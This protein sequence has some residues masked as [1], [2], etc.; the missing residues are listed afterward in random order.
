MLCSG[1]NGEDAI[2]LLGNMMELVWVPL[3]IK[4]SKAFLHALEV[5]QSIPIP[6]RKVYGSYERAFSVNELCLK[7][8]LLVYAVLVHALESS[9]DL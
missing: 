7:P 9:D 5:C 8:R 6:E 3:R 2:F 4:R 1:E